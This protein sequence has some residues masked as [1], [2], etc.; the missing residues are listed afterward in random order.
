MS[1]PKTEAVLAEADA[2]LDAS[3]GRLFELL[4][5]PSVSTDPA[6]KADVDRAADWCVNE[7]NGIGLPA[8]NGR[9]PAIR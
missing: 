4:A 5:I 6:Y 7:L 1:H 2:E 3:L 8:A 9:R